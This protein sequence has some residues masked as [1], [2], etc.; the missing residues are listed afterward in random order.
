MPRRQRSKRAT[1][2]IAIIDGAARGNPG[3]AAYGIV[4]KDAAGK[5]LARLN[6]RLG[7]TT[8]NVAEYRALLAALNHARQEGWRRLRV[9]TDS[10][11]LARQLDGSYKVR[12]ADLKPL[13]AEAQQL[14]HQ[15]ESFAVESVPRVHT[16]EADKLANAAL[17]RRP[18]GPRPQGKP[19]TE[20]LKI[21]EARAEDSARLA[22]LSEQLG[23]PVSAEEI[24]RRLRQVQRDERHAV[25]VAEVAG[26]LVGWLHVFIC[27]QLLTHAQAE[28]G[29]LVVEVNS[30]AQGVGKILMRQA[31]EWARARGC[32]AVY[33]R[34]N[35]IRADAHRFYEQLGYTR[36]KTQHAFRK[37]L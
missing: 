13:H 25:Y 7:E 35:I 32:R 2:V 17:D 24:G 30:R 20:K 11:L 15:L 19:A 33:L 4:F 23:Y 18:F 16:R 26:Q 22:V 14:I 31:E 10:E 5:T 21:R 29:G 27:P 34:T 36:I 8:N 28:I 9:Q 6:G 12:S 37:P 1:P 3:P